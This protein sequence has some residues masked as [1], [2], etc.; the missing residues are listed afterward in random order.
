MRN[1]PDSEPIEVVDLTIHAIGRIG[2]DRICPFRAEINP[3][4]NPNRA[5]GN[6]LL[7][8]GLAFRVRGNTIGTTKRQPNPAMR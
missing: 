2:E 7:L 1:R 6:N 8:A 5:S 3:L 4:Q